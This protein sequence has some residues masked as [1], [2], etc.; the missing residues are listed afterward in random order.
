MLTVTHVSIAVSDGAAAC[1]P[2]AEIPAIG[3]Q[4]GWLRGEQS[5]V[6]VLW[7]L[8]LYEFLNPWLRLPQIGPLVMTIALLVLLRRARLARRGTRAAVVRAP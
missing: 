4:N 6:A 1:G 3:S 5:F 8:P 7:A 2:V